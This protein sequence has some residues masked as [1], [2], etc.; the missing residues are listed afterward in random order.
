MMWSMIGA[1]MGHVII[2]RIVHLKPENYHRR[3]F[4]KFPDMNRIGRTASS[5]SNGSGTSGGCLGKRGACRGLRAACP[6]LT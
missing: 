2:E 5:A 3:M 1:L 4:L 6:V